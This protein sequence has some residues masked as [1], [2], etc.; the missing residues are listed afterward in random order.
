[1]L[2]TA[3][4]ARVE[5]TFVVSVHGDEQYAR[6]VQKYLLCRIA[7]MSIPVKDGHSFDA[8][9]FLGV[10]GSSSHVVEE[11][12][13]ADLVAYASMVAW[14]SDSRK[15]ISPLFLEQVVDTDFHRSNR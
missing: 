5:A 10:P 8:V 13:T 14:R 9:G 3:D 6:I 7:V 1:V 4:L 15:T 12:K 11:A 2:Q